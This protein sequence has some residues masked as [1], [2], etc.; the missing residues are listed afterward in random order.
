MSTNRLQR[1]KGNKYDMD[2]TNFRVLRV[3]TGAKNY[4][5]SSAEAILELESQTIAPSLY[6]AT[7]RTNQDTNVELNDKIKYG[8]NN[9]DDDYTKS[10]SNDHQ[11]T[12]NSSVKL[13]YYT[14]GILLFVLVTFVLH[15]AV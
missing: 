4:M 3:F 12:T 14:T 11:Q 8:H 6:E 5:Y 15:P 13:D 2:E 9:D 7:P 1:F 10:F